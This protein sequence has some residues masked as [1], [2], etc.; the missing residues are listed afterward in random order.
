M[1][2]VS[3]SEENVAIWPA[4]G[5]VARVYDEEQNDVDSMEAD[6]VWT[7]YWELRWNAMP[8]AVD[9]LIY[10]ATPEGISM[11]PR[12][13]NEPCWRLAVARGTGL[14]RDRSE[15]DWK[16]QLRLTTMQLQV[17]IV[18]RLLDGSVVPAP[19]HFPVGALLA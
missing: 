16:A 12:H 10:Y 2:T 9:Y 11:K 17:I 3:S 13:T 19:R 5:F 15:L 8:E 4:S 14:I 6:S 18:A 1:V 7:T